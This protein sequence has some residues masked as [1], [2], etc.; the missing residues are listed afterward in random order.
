MKG[1]VNGMKK[2]FISQPMKDRTDEQ[3]LVERE[4]AINAAK[5]LLG[6]DV[7]VIADCQAYNRTKPNNHV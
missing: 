1:S 3:I 2:L 7:E 5:E 4:K 6:D